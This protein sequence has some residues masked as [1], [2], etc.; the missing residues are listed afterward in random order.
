[1]LPGIC[2]SVSP[3]AMAS[4]RSAPTA[5]AAPAPAVKA[6]AQ[7]AAEKA[8]ADD[9]DDA[10]IGALTIEEAL[11]KFNASRPLREI[12]GERFVDAL[13]AV[14]EAEFEAYNRVISSWERENLLL[15]V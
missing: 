6:A 13:T 5:R 8:G 1:M 3:G 9:L 14:K 4:V 15:N 12:F 11:A 2:A 7:P 10:E